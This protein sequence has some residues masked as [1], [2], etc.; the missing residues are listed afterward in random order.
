VFEMDGET[1]IAPVPELDDWVEALKLA[2]EWDAAAARAA[3]PSGEPPSTDHLRGR[4]D[5]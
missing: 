5:C 2:A 4:T 3:Q 1:C